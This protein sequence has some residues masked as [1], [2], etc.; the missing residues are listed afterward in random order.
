M[1]FL[2]RTNDYILNDAMPY[3]IHTSPELHSQSKKEETSSTFSCL[4]LS[5]CLKIIKILST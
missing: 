2:A 4:S 1:D 3:F 5:I